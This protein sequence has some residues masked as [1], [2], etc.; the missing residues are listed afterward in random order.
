VSLEADLH[1]ALQKHELQLLFQPIVELQTRTM[2]GAEALLRWYHPVEGVL[3]P[4]QFLGLAE[5]AGLMGPIARWVILRVC[6][7]AGDWR[8]RLPP[9]QPFFI[10]INLSPTTLRD[11]GLGDYVASCVNELGLPASVLKFELTE[12]A[13]LSNVAAARETLD[14]LHS[15]G[16]HL[17][18]DDFGTG[19]SSLSHL[20]L[21]PFDFVKIDRPLVNRTGPDQAATGLTAAMVQ[22]AR[23]LRLTAI[24]E[25]VESEAAATALQ[26]MGCDYGQGFYFSEP[27]E[28]P[29]AFH[30]LYSRQPFATAAMT[31]ETMELQALEDADDSPTIMIPADSVHLHEH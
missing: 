16:F 4:A 20:Q 5:D 22:M 25:V 10:S 2:V 6:R 27:L 9:D 13:L 11:P 26:A 29:A 30:R 21:F 3:T 28:A 24:A 17:M 23:S 8:G 1:I 18:L 12:A 31:A 15:M 14:T 7:L 19:Y